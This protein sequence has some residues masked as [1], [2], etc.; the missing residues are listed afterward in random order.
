MPPAFSLLPDAQ[1][2]N[3]SVTLHPSCPLSLTSISKSDEIHPKICPRS[4][5]CSLYLT[6]TAMVPVPIVSRLEASVASSLISQLPLLLC[7]SLF[8]MELNIIRRV[9][10]LLN[11]NGFLSC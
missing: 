4:N 8:S 10:P 7:Q 1:A 3:L 5:Y 2:Q 11:T 6:T 9:T